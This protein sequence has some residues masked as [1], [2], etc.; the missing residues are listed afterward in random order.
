MRLV[1]V[2]DTSLGSPVAACSA[3]ESGARSDEVDGWRV[4]LAV[5]VGGVQGFE[6]IVACRYTPLLYFY[7]ML[8]I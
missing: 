1:L 8:E 3:L 6:L 7:V 4:F 2:G 5:V